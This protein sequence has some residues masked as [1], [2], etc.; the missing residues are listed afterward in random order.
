M[1]EEAAWRRILEG[2]NNFQVQHICIF[3]ARYEILLMNSFIQFAECERIEIFA[4]QAC[5]FLI[6][7]LYFYRGIHPT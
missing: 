7:L 3:G 2:C 6:F 5:E 4:F 1:Y